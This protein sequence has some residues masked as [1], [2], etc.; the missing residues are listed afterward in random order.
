MLNYISALNERSYATLCCRSIYL[1]YTNTTQQTEAWEYLKPRTV[2][3]ALKLLFYCESLYSL[4]CFETT[5]FNFELI[6]NCYGLLHV[7]LL[8]Y[9]NANSINQEKNCISLS[10][11]TMVT[12]MRVIVEGVRNGLHASYTVPKFGLHGLF[13]LTNHKAF[14]CTVVSLVQAKHWLIIQIDDFNM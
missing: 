12:D 1:R 5:A 8:W 3:N 4:T 11:Y 13:P 9:G 10:S 6:G 7:D 14:N 2:G